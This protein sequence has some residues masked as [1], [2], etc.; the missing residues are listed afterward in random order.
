M[1]PKT[2]V[3]VLTPGALECDLLCRNSKFRHGPARL[4]SALIQRLVS[5][6]DEGNFDTDTERQVKI[7]AIHLQAKECQGLLAT[8][9]ARRS[10]E[11]M[12]LRTSRKNQPCQQLDFGLLASRL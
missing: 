6:W 9:E 11:Q 12:L 3:Q 5:L 7:E 8:T 2:Y 4:E 1:F 10:M